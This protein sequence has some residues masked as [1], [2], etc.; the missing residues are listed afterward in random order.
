MTSRLH[1]TVESIGG[2]LAQDVMTCHLATVGEDATV[3]EALRV[4]RHW[5][6]R[7]LPVTEHGLFLG[8]VDD[9][10]VSCALKAGADG[11]LSL[12][13][14]VDEVMSRY[15]PQV[16]PATPLGRVA[17]LLGTSRADAVAVIDEQDHLLGL[18]TLVDV[19]G[20]VAQPEAPPRGA[21]HGVRQTGS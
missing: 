12:E 15:V 7:H 8:L 13:Q 2:L 19:V 20:A 17:R 4:M 10:M 16:G 1:E 6:V 5:G 9:R 18:I 11:E 3:A 14:R 21:V